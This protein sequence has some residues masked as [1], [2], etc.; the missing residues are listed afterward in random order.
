MYTHTDTGK[1]LQVLKLHLLGEEYYTNRRKKNYAIQ[2]IVISL[3]FY[4]DNSIRKCMSRSNKANN[5]ARRKMKANSMVS[6]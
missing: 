2:R 3:I 4:S 5:I 1:S 6:F